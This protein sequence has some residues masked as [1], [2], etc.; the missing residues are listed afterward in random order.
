MTKKL[1]YQK[2]LK[3]ENIQPKNAYVFGDSCENDLQPAEKL[4]M[5]TYLVKNATDIPSIVK[6][7]L[8]HTK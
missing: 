2:I 6:N 7:A 8:Q 4:G 1:Y 3:K 5:N